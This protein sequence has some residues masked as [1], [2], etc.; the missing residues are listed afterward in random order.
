ME[1]ES[2]MSEGQVAIAYSAEPQPGG[3]GPRG[4]VSRRNL[5]DPQIMRQAAIDAVRKLD[6]RV[7]IKNP[8]MFV[9]LVGTVVTLI[10]SIANPS[11]FAWSVTVWL[12]LTVLFANFAEAMAEGRG[13][14]QADTLR[15]TRSTTTPGASCPAAARSGRRGRVEHRGHG[16]LRGR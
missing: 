14:A 11:V 15:K 8:V 9:V 6:P 12:A 7:Q 4:V 10:D 3:P 16:G 1:R 2:V 13:K 5:F